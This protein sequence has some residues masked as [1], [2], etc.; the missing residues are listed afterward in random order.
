[1]SRLPKFITIVAVVL[2]AAAVFAVGA[3]AEE[4]TTAPADYEGVCLIGDADLSGSVDAADA[5]VILR[6]AARLDELTDPVALKRADLDGNSTVN[7]IDARMAL[8]IAAKLDAS[9]DHEWGAWTLVTKGDC[10][11]EGSEERECRLCALKQT[12]ATEKDPSDHA[13]YGTTVVGEVPAGCETA[14][15]TG[16]AVCAGCGALINAG[17]EIPATGHRWGAGVETT[18]PTCTEPGVMT[19]TCSSCG[20]TKTG[21]GSAATGHSWDGGVETTPP[22][23]TSPGVVTFTCTGCGL[24]RTE[25]GSPVTDHTWDDGVITTAATCTEEGVRTFTCTGCGLTRT[26]SVPVDPSYHAGYGTKTI[27]ASDP[28]CTTDGYTG[29]SA[30][31]GCGAVLSTGS[32][33]PAFGHSW[34]DWTV[35]KAPDEIHEGEDIRTCTTCGATETKQTP[36]VPAEEQPAETAVAPWGA[37]FIYYMPTAESQDHAVRIVDKSGVSYIFLPSGADTAALKLFSA[38]GGDITLTQNG[39]SMAKH[40]GNTFNISLFDGDDLNGYEL[41]VTNG[42]TSQNVVFLRSANV[43]S[44][45]LSSKDP[46]EKGRSWVDASKSNKAEGSYAFLNA[47]GSTAFSGAVS[48]IKARGNSTFDCFDKKAY[49]VKLD[50]KAAL[51][52][53]GKSNAAKKWILLANAMDATQIHDA[54]AF[55]L[56]AECGLAY[57]P[58]FE[59]IDLWYDS[60]Y[61]GTYLLCEKVEIG[62]GRVNIE[63]V[64]DAIEDANISEAFDSDD[65]GVTIADTK[66]G[67]I[68]AENVKINDIESAMRYG[69]YRYVT[70]LTTEPD[71]PDGATHHSY[72]LELDS[73]DRS[74][75]EITGFATSRGHYFTAKSPEY[76]TAGTMQWVASFWQEFEDAVYS[77]DGY[78]AATGKYWYDYIDGDSLVKLYLINEFTK[79]K[80]SFFSSSFFYIPEN[81]DKIYAGPVWDYDL[82]FGNSTQREDDM[83][84]PTGLYVTD[85]YPVEQLLTVSSFT[86]AVK[87]QLAE[88]ADFRKAAETLVGENGFIR[89]YI[90]LLKNT[91]NM[92]YKIWNINMWDWAIRATTGPSSRA[93]SRGRSRTPSTSWRPGA[94]TDSRG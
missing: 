20:Q 78:N 2:L 52:G 23:C 25:T 49:Q 71:L 14:G 59:V 80:D 56:A 26:E 73:K 85:R 87:A 7:A 10:S 74:C 90:P 47:D 93:A 86:D 83:V 54:A 60:A 29:D 16:D 18:P 55:Q 1:M 19:F 58:E 79:N 61:R 82:A 68:L 70:D 36:A 94:R 44:L 81:K 6:V 67:T 38:D 48:A 34:S 4:G 5:R 50:K 8:R 11:F 64:D 92:N 33:I 27:N 57:T 84:D 43:R 63:D 22:T 42:E 45:F 13:A 69:T 32:A 9:P 12:R 77:P 41:T 40:C 24:T 39:R 15:F 21:E 62:S 37:S 3:F 89:S 72:L 31:A 53:G 51:L 88:G 65:P 76:G 91:T 28:T 66:T 75:K 30:C 35:S 17:F 46:D